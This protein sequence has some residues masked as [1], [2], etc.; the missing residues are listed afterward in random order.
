MN[1][2]GVIIDNIIL[3][4]FITAVILFLYNYFIY[5]L[6]VISLSRLITDKHIK[7]IDTHNNYPSVSFI[8]AAYNEEKVIKAKIKNTLSIDYPSELIQIIVVSDGSSDS[9]PKI[10]KEFLPKGIISL[11]DTE[12]KGKSAALNRGVELSTGEIIIFSDANNDFSNDSIKQLV[13]HFCDPKIGAVTGAK[14]IYDSESRQSAMGDGLYWKYESR[15]KEAES[16]LGSI[17]GAEGEIL[18]VRKKLF[19]PINASVI[20]DDAAITFNVVSSGY[21]ILYEK[22]AKAYEEA[23]KDLIDDF[24]V[25]VR[26]TAGGFQ[27][28]SLQK[29]Y[30]LTHLSWF[31]FT[32]ISHKILRWLA[33]HFLIIILIS[34]LFLLDR[35]EMKI[36]MVL[37]FLFYTISLYGWFNRNKKINKLIYIPMYFS[38]MNYALFV[39]FLRYINKNT[40]TI[41]KKADR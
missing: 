35:L 17:T 29:K 22:N 28:L 13:K 7:Q 39:G 2:F 9:T 31:S 33:P 41:W 3:S 10:V 11:H 1:V 36:L 20:N 8:V 16:V 32:F 24:N 40:K 5:P 25:K 30:L 38:A 14:H 18:A 37:Q 34:P 15:I 19:K 23:S 6:L 21:R 27:T 12:R 4:I 26:M